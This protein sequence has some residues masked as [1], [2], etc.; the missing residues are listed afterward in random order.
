MAPE[1]AGEDLYRRERQSGRTLVT[2]GMCSMEKLNSNISSSHHSSM[3]ESLR[4]SSMYSKAL[5]SV[6]MVKRRPAK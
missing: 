2:P 3:S 1:E 4:C 6:Y 5:G